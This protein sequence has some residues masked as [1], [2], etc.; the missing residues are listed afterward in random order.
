MDRSFLDAQLE[1]AARA[2]CQVYPGVEINYR[3]DI[4]RTTPAYVAESLAAVNACDFGGAAL[5][6][7]VMLAP[8]AHIDA[9]A[10][11]SSRP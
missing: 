7:N 8:D 6:W 10:A 4:A 3:A 11:F 2:G 1:A 5:C 9:A